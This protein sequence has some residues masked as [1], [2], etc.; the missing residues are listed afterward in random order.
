M[1]IEYCEFSSNP[2]KCKA[3]LE[4]NLPEVF[5]QMSTGEQ[6]GEEDGSKKKSRQNRGGKGQWSKKAVEQKVSVSRASRGKNKFTTSI[7]GLDTYGLLTFPNGLFLFQPVP[8][9]V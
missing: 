3:W 4:E 2:A 6:A 7:I 9:L 8:F 1:P 5:H